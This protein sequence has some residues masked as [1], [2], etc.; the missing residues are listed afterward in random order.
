MLNRKIKI[1][2]II[3]LAAFLLYFVGFTH[4]QVSI[5][6]H[7]ANSG[8]GIAVGYINIVLFYLFTLSLLLMIAWVIAYR[9]SG[10][11]LALVIFLVVIGFIY[12]LFQVE[13]L[14]FSLRLQDYISKRLI[15][16]SPTS[17]ANLFGYQDL[18]NWVAGYCQ[19]HEAIKKKDLV[20]C[21][22]VI[23][24]GYRMKCESVL[25]LLSPA[26]PPES[27]CIPEEYESCKSFASG[28]GTEYFRDQCLGDLGDCYL[29][30]A[31]RRCDRSICQK[32]EHERLRN[33]CLDP[34]HPFYGCQQP[35][36]EF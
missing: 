32:I 12:L 34:S 23:E 28:E 3:W 27:I 35:V 2:S 17:F 20:L 26:V 6:V 5:M 16:L 4:L 25:T 24:A 29:K 36:L 31:K 18:K 14:Q 10:K 19:Y 15:C 21:Q 13:R 33:L 8:G 30:I 1:L 7:Q 9:A 11:Y 22:K